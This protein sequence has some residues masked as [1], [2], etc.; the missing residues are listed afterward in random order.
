MG[1]C[2]AWDLHRPIRT[3]PFWSANFLP[4]YISI[5]IFYVNISFFARSIKLLKIKSNK[6][7]LRQLM[8][9]RHN[10]SKTLRFAKRHLKELFVSTNN[11]FIASSLSVFVGWVTH[12]TGAC[13]CGYHPNFT[14]RFCYNLGILLA[15]CPRA[16]SAL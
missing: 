1:W 4:L 14:G 12:I 16:N 3:S 15:S 6:S 8:I 5:F 13:G 10:R 2:L 9:Y 7:T 11:K